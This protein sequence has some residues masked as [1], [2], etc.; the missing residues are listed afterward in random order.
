MNL[1]E[2]RRLGF[3]ESHHIPFTKQYRV[4]CHACEAMVI[5]GIP[6]H[7]TGCLEAR[8]ECRGCNELI[9]TTRRYCDSC[10]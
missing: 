10:S 2:L 7:E 5:N 9:P 4:R 3:T 8:H 6:C 1:D